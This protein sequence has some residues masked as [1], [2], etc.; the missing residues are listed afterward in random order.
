MVPDEGDEEDQPHLDAVMEEPPCV[1]MQQLEQEFEDI[2]ADEPGSYI[3]Y[4]PLH[5]PWDGS[6][7]KGAFTG[8][9]KLDP[10]DMDFLDAEVEGWAAVDL[11]RRHYRPG[12]FQ[13][14][15]LPPRHQLR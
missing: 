5:I 11:C 1:E 13:R 6:I 12:I 2:F 3:D 15:C 8:G 7:P 9:Y 10:E 4:P 14:G